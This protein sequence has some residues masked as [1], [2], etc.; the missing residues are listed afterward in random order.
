MKATREKMAKEVELLSLKTSKSIDNEAKKLVSSIFSQN[1]LDLIM[2]KKKTVHWS[3]DEISK[4]FAL[5][6]ISKRAYIY[7]KNELHYPL[8]GKKCFVFLISNV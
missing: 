3:R 6:Y 7:V 2:K 1:Q 4:A 5:S 8:P